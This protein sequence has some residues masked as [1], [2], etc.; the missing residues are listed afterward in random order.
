MKRRY[1]IQKQI[2]HSVMDFN[3]KLTEI[4]INYDIDE[5]ND[6]K[7]DDTI[8]IHLGR[9]QFELKKIKR[10]NLSSFL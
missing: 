8:N 3:Y 1:V 2:I 6:I 4:A 10:K 7:E 5:N 9:V